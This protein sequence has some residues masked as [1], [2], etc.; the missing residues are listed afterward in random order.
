LLCQVRRPANPAVEQPWPRLVQ[1]EGDGG[2][3]DDL[4][5]AVGRHGPRERVGGVGAVGESVRVP[6]DQ[7]GRHVAAGAR[8]PKRGEQERARVSLQPVAGDAGDAGPSG[9]PELGEAR[10]RV[11]HHRIQQVVGEGLPVRPR[12]S[13]VGREEAVTS[14]QTG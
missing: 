1:G 6:L 9:Q 7:R 4:L 2:R 13:R 12:P 5:R 8:D 10:H 3:L 11:R 14:R